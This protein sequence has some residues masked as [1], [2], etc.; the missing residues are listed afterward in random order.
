V[1]SLPN[2]SFLFGRW[3]HKT[4]VS[5]TICNNFAC[6]GWAVWHIWH[7]ASLDSTSR[8]LLVIS[9]NLGPI[10]HRLA[11]VHPSKP[12]KWHLNPSYGL[13]RVHECDKRQRYGE[14]CRNRRNRL[15]CKKRFHL[16][17]RTCKAVFKI[18]SSQSICEKSQ[19]YVKIVFVW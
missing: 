8:V 4:D 1:A 12:A 5:V 6:F 11:T 2:F 3:Q 16:I 10:L 19:N 7:S 15:R 13:S 14:M 9:S 18:S 17:M